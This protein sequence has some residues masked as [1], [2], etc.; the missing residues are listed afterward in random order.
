MATTC[1]DPVFWG[2]AI[3]TDVGAKTLKLSRLKMARVTRDGGVIFETLNTTYSAVFCN[4]LTREK[5][6]KTCETLGKLEKD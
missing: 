5:F 1:K 4:A 6:L 3:Y 2:T